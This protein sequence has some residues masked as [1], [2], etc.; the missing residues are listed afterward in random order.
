MAES[1]SQNGRALERESSFENGISSQLLSQSLSSDWSEYNFNY[2][3]LENR[4][5]IVKQEFG[6]RRAVS[7]Q[8]IS[9]ESRTFAELLDLEVERVVLHYLRIQGLLAGSVWLLRSKQHSCI[10]GSLQTRLWR[11]QLTSQRE[12][13]EELLKECRCAAREVLRLLEYLE[14]NTINLRKILMQ[15]DQ[16]F[17]TKLSILYFDTRVS[18]TNSPLLQLYQFIIIWVPNNYVICKGSK[19]YRP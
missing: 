1:P 9:G 10:E 19:H 6:M 7:V 2:S 4:L 16:L 15:H 8:S 5:F 13:F 14:F 11:R 18:K 17:D 3:M 12:K